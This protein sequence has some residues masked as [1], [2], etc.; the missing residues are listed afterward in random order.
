MKG[1]NEKYAKLGERNGKVVTLLLE[2]WGPLHI[3]G[4]VAARNFKHVYRSS[5]DLLSLVKFM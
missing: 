1:T 3:S 4:M 5:S 2:F